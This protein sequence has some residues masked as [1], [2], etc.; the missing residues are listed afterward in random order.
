MQLTEWPSIMPDDHTVL[1]PGTVLTLEP[2]IEFAPG[3]QIVHEEDIVIT[4]DGA[5]LLTRRAPRE[6]PAVT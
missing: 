5:Q 4:E 3:K 6:L 2:G 1:E